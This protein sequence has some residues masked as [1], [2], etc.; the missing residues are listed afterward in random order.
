MTHP[1]AAVGALVIRK[2]QVL[3]V[4]RRN[5]PN[6]GLWTI[7]GGKIE[8]GETLQQAAEREIFEETGVTIKAGKPI[9]TFDLI[10]EQD[11]CHYVI[12]D[13]L[14]EYI[15]GD[16]NASDDAIAAQWFNRNKLH[17]RTIENKT[18][19]LINHNWPLSHF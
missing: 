4:K 13:L 16:I 2:N 9:Y 18:I 1:I 14:A 7:P 6:Q 3:L 5:P 11:Q 12:V 17:G 15:S 10:D 8:Y 19:E